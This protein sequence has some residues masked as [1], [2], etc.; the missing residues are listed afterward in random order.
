[1][2]LLVTGTVGIDTIHAPTGQAEN[3]LGGSAVYFGAAAS[4]L[5]PTKVRLVAAAGEDLPEE[6]HATMRSFEN[7]CLAGLEVREGSETFRWGGRYHDEDWNQRDTLFTDLNILEEAPPTPPVEYADSKLVFLANTHPSIQKNFLDHFTERTL[8]V[9]DTMNLW[10]DIAHEELLDLFKHIDG[11]V[12]NDQEAFQ[13]TEEGNVMTAGRKILEYGLTF[14]VI[15]KGEHGAL[16]VHRDGVASLPAFPTETVIDPTGAG[17]SF[18]GGMMGY[19]SDVV[20]K[21]GDPSSLESIRRGIARG[22]VVASYTIETFSLDRLRGI[23]RQD[24]DARFQAF[25]HAVK[26]D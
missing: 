12:M 24:V 20:D 18:A 22:T 9:A 2:S 7:L 8:S 13:L 1:M 6:H 26:V 23:S 11:V 10:I 19:L 14:C 3:V 21:G 4:L 17:D 15:K 16:V 5:S 25:A